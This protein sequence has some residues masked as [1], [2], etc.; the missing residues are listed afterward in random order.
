[1]LKRILKVNSHNPV[2]K[3]LSGFGKA[4]NKL[5]ENRNHDSYT[6]G[7]VTVLKKIAKFTPA[8]I[9]DGGA[10]TGGYT[11]LINAYIPDCSIYSFEPV[12]ET[13]NK[14][15]DNLK[16][17]KDT[18]PINKGLY[19]KNCVMDIN[20]YPSDE[21]SSIYY[22]EG[23]SQT[24]PVVVQIDLV[25]GDTFLAENGIERVDFLKLDLE[26]AEFDALL[27]FEAA[28]KNN[29]INIIQ[30]EYG[31]INISTKK[32]L[33]DYYKLLESYD[34]VVGKIYPKNVEFRKYKFQHEDFIGPNYIA[35]KKNEENILKALAE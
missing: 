32:L 4:M 9:I 7:E 6:N 8:V 12:K 30:F 17:V 2:L 35:V 21:H 14:L 34:Y 15:K 3:V 5:Y 25:K 29:K 13:F 11:K 22:L 31:Y 18:F 23:L 10:N 28:L 26:G 20:V 33:I 1:M 19:A 27:G 24:V 16:N